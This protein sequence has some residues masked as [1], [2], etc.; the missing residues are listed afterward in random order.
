MGGGSPQRIHEVGNTTMDRCIVFLAH[1][2]N[3]M[4]DKYI[5]Q[6]FKPTWL[7]L[8]M[9]QWIGYN[10]VSDNPHAQERLEGDSP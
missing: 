8:R 9:V 5:G 2:A 7:K 1:V 4:V 6:W 10:T 3:D